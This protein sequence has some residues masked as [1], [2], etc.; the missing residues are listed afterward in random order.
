MP[1]WSKTTRS[2][3]ASS[4]L[5]ELGEVRGE[6][7][8]RLPGAAGQRD[9][10]LV[11]RGARRRAWSTRCRSRRRRRPSGRRARPPF[12][13]A[14]CRRRRTRACRAPR[15]R[16]A[17]CRGA[18][19]RRAAGA[20]APA[21]GERASGRTVADGPAPD[22]A[23]SNGRPAWDDRAAA[24]G[25]V[26]PPRGAA[27]SHH[28]QIVNAPGAPAAVGPYSHAVRAGGL[29]FCSGQTPL[30]PATNTLVE[31]TV[32]GSHAALPGQ[33]RGRVRGRGR[34]SRRRGAVRG[35]RDRPRPSSPT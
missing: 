33:P 17:P 10:G 2:R 26:V 9:H 13:S 21:G 4:G 7:Q 19:A 30:D 12:R 29:L 20:A 23:L 31:G 18:R 3:P 34:R 22:A 11:G 32:G 6:R 5:S 8:R 16:A 14:A 35:L 28:R 15:A 25:R 27:V 24:R 1:R